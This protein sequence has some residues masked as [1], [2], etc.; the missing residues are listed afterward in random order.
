MTSVDT[1]CIPV[2]DCPHCNNKNVPLSCEGIES[3]PAGENVYVWMCPMCERVVNTVEGVYIKDLISLR[4][5]KSGDWQAK[6]LTPEEADAGNR[7]S[8]E[9]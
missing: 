2:V 1:K 3:G 7:A 4:D 5:L 6:Q 9:G 8:A